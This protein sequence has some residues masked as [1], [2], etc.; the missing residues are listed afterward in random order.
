MRPACCPTRSRELPNRTAGSGADRACEPPRRMA[1]ARQ[2][3]RHGGVRGHPSWDRPRVKAGRA[4]QAPRPGEGLA[5]GPDPTL[6]DMGSPSPEA[7][8]DVAE[9]PSQVRDRPTLDAPPGGVRPN[10]EHTRRGERT[11]P[12]DDDRRREGE[13][14]WKEGGFSR[15]SGRITDRR[16]AAAGRVAPRIH[17]AADG[18]SCPGPG[19]GRLTALHAPDAGGQLQRLVRQPPALRQETARSACHLGPELGRPEARR[20]ETA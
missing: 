13:T 4:P 3:P 7:R 20:A 15:S 1:E 6:Y 12:T 5:E 2:P 11:R 19:G 17:P 16:S 18:A 14:S 10:E 8:G 9:G